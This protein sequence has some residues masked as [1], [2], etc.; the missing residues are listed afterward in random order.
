M[1]I[2]DTPPNVSSFI[3]SLRDIGYTFEIAVADIL[4]N[5]LTANSKNI[6]IYAVESPKLVFCILDD[7]IGMDEDSLREAMRLSTKD[8]DSHRGESDLGRFGLGLK[9]ASFSQCRLL[10]VISKTNKSQ[11]SGKQWDIEQVI[12]SNSWALNSLDENDIKIIIDKL[13]GMDLYE[14][15]LHQKSGTLVIW[16]DIDR[17]EEDSLTMHL[18]NLREHLALVFHRFIDGIKKTHKV[19]FSINNAKIKGFNP[20]YNSDKQEQVNYKINKKIVSVQPHIMP[21]FRKSTKEVYNKYGTSNGYSRSQ[22]CYLYR[23]NRLIAE[24]TWWKIIKNQDSNQLVRVE[25][26][27]SNNQDKEWGVAV[28]KSGYGVIPPIGIR[29]ELKVLFREITRRGRNT[30]A[31]RIRNTSIEK[32]WE[33]FRKDQKNSFKVNKKHPLWQEIIEGLDEERSKVLSLYLTAL[34]AYLPVEAIHREMIN[35]PHDLQQKASLDINIVANFIE[36]LIDKGLTEEE[37]S[38]FIRAEGF[39]KE[40]FDNA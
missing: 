12:N 5:C 24:A 9:T 22:G 4:D 26:N 11:I 34:E 40:M 36:K 20:F 6:D 21:S 39:D 14:K 37:I 25:I 23:A 35:K 28:T 1:H 7:G 17:V 8:P 38:S 18:S 29:D 30:Q 13:K 3:K 27:I 31:A 16:Q 33:I 10:T 2:E 32:Y 19:N 15:L